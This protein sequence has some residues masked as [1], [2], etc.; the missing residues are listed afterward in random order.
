MKKILVEEIND[1]LSLSEI[2]DKALVCLSNAPKPVTAAAVAHA[3]GL[4]ASEITRMRQHWKRPDE[5]RRV[6]GHFLARLV[7]FLFRRYPRLVVWQRKDGSYAVRL[8]KRIKGVP[9]E[10]ISEPTPA[11]RVHAPR[12]GTTR[13]FLYHTE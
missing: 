6:P 4:H 12:P 10:Q 11:L 8:L 1:L 9:F 2:A 7:R 13:W 5:P 3:L